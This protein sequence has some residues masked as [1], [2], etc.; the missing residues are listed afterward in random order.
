MQR[1]NE[2]KVEKAEKKAAAA[3]ARREE[4]SKT[5]KVDSSADREKDSINSVEEEDL[6]KTPASITSSDG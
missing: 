6:L 1:H 3:K 5:A 2:Y 4:K